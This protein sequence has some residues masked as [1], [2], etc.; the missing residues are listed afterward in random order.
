MFRQEFKNFYKSLVLCKIY[1]ASVVLYWLYR[2]MKCKAVGGYCEYMGYVAIVKDIGKK[3]DNSTWF[4]HT[5]KNYATCEKDVI[6]MTEDRRGLW[7][8]SPGTTR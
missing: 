6:E 5:Y 1:I 8:F 4:V 2:F 3:K 7:V